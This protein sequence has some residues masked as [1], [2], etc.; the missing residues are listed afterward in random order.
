MPMIWSRRHLDAD[1]CT[2]KEC[3]VNTESNPV[4]ATAFERFMETTLRAIQLDTPMELKFNSHDFSVFLFS[5]SHVK[6]EYAGSLHTLTD[7]EIAPEKTVKDAVRYPNI[8]SGLYPAFASPV[9]IQ[10][11]SRDG[12]EHACI[13]NLDELFKDRRVLHSEPTERLYKPSPIGGGVPTIIIELDDRK[14]NIYM[15]ACMQIVP[16]VNRPTK[17]SLVEHRTLVYSHQF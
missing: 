9:S 8:K 6:I 16:D 15:F 11:R 12:Q 1:N 5:V 14:V 17:R 13:I 2:G 10:W 7:D 4:D 3:E